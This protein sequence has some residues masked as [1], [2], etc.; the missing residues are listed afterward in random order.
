[1]F[2]RKVLQIPEVVPDTNVADPRYSDVNFFNT[3]NSL[4]PTI[5][6]LTR[7]SSFSHL[8]PFDIFIPVVVT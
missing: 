1:M 7:L 8:L 3:Q 2:W 6:P 4:P 5:L